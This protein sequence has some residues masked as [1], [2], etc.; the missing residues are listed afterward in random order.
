MLS[1]ARGAAPG[2][3][4]FS[5]RRHKM[6]P[7]LRR[8]RLAGGKVRRGQGRR[9]SAPLCLWPEGP[10]SPAGRAPAARREFWPFSREGWVVRWE[11]VGYGRPTPVRR[12]AARGGFVCPPR[13]RS[14]GWRCPRGA[15]PPSPGCLRPHSRAS[16][17][18]CICEKNKRVTNCRMANGACWCDSVGSGV[19]V[20]CNTREYSGRAGRPWPAC[21]PWCGAGRESVG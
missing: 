19:S 7:P 10:S 17:P 3:R 15:G 21:A 9:A 6:A 5:A 16:L 11:A 8:G 20:N 13:R 1:A 2:G 4:P 12:R 14:S 18:A